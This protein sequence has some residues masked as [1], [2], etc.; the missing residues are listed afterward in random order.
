[1]RMRMRF[2]CAL[3]VAVAALSG[4]ASAVTLDQVVALSKAGVSEAVILALIDRDQ[5][6]FSIEPE[7]LV[8]LHHDGISEALVLAMLKSGRQEGE[9]A[10]RAEA[11]WN[12]STMTAAIE[13][14]PQVAFV[15]HGPDR[16]NT[17]YF[18]DFYSGQAFIPSYAS[19]WRRSIIPSFDARLFDAPRQLCLAQVNTAHS[20]GSLSFVTECPAVMQR[21]RIR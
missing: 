13:T 3:M 15:G 16:P 14:A 20:T 11:E 1:M 10:A 19:S 4:T 9:D 7:Q 12:A 18:S 2:P 8:T 17:S 5:T 6:V 21:R